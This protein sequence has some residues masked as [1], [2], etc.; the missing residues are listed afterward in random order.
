VRDTGSVGNNP[1]F[2]VSD[3]VGQRHDS[4]GQESWHR[5]GD[6]VPADLRY[7]S[8]V[9][10]FCLM[11]SCLLMSEVHASIARL[12]QAMGD[13]ACACRS[14]RMRAKKHF[15]R[16]FTMLAIIMLPTV[17]SAG[18]TAYGGMEAAL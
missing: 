3:G 5:L 17:M 8:R 4:D 14:A 16:T 15:K 13:V 12:M 7:V 10:G 11:P 2:T 18:P 6:H 9:V 1:R